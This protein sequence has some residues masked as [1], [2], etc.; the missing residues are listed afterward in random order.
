MAK[1]VVASMKGD[2]KFAKV[3][4]MVKG[5]KGAYKFVEEIVPTDEVKEYLNEK[6]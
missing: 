4:R 3:I 5:K 6:V 2:S 1:K